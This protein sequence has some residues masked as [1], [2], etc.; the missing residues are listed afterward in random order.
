MIEAVI[1]S[2]QRSP[3]TKANGG[4]GHPVAASVAAELA[5]EYGS[6]KMVLLQDGDS[7]AYRLECADCAAFGDD[8]GTATLK[9]NKNGTATVSGKL[10]GLYSF[11]AT[12]T[13]MFDTECRDFDMDLYGEHCHAV[14]TPV[15]KVKVCA[16]SYSGEKCITETEL[17]TIR[18]QP[19]DE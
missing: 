18:W 11:T 2:A 6:K 5:S 7:D 1:D 9:M 13:L 17:V 4:Y 8:Y 10:Y 16:H 3:F 12:A 14:F 15:V 19:L